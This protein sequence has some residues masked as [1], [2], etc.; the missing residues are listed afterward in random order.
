MKHQEELCASLPQ[1]HLTIRASWCQAHQAWTLATHVL[2]EQGEAA[3]SDVVPYT[4]VRFGPFDDWE[5]VA[6]AAESALATALEVIG[7]RTVGS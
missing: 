4:E 5:V 6:A 3:I 2:S 1:Y 7:D